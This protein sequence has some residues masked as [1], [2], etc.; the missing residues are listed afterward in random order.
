MAASVRRLC[1]D[2]PT[3]TTTT[4]QQNGLTRVGCHR[5][6][7]PYQGRRKKL[8]SLLLMARA[9]AKPRLGPVMGFCSTFQATILQGVVGAEW[10]E[11]EE[12]DIADPGKLKLRPNGSAPAHCLDHKCPF[13]V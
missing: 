1:S 9:Y 8:T 5:G 6:D 11:A 3:T 2:T 7:V 12:K 13:L 4:R 10:V